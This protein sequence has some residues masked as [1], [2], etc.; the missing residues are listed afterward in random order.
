MKPLGLFLSSD[1]LDKEFL[2]VCRIAKKNKIEKDIGVALS[3]RTAD[4]ILVVIQ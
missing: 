4:C 1:T 2:S 3:Q